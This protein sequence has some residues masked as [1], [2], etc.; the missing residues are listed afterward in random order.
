MQLK[1]FIEEILVGALSQSNLANVLLPNIVNLNP[2]LP[3]MAKNSFPIMLGKLITATNLGLTQ[4]YTELPLA[5]EEIF[6]D[7]NPSMDRYQLSIQHAEFA[8]AAYPDQKWIADS[9]YS[10]FRDNI[11]ECLYVADEFGARWW[12]NDANATWNVNFPTPTLIQVPFSECDISLSITYKAN[13]PKIPFSVTRQ[14]LQADGITYGYTNPEMTFELPQFLEN[15]LTCFVASKYYASIGSAE[16]IAQSQGL[17]AEF[18]NA[19][20]TI[21]NQQIIHGDFTEMD[22]LTNNGWV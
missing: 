21:K 9:K 1:T 4:I 3:V 18:M 14:I 12:T 22:N 10:P 19:I 2:E 7:T 17:Y 11:I 20:Q 6:L 13:H 16:A 15:A 8:G 5:E